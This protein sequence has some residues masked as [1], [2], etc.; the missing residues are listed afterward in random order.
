MVAEH[1]LLGLAS[2]VIL[3]VMGLRILRAASTR[4]AKALAA[5]ML[6]YSVLSLSVDG[7]RLVAP[8]FA[9]GISSAT[10]ASPRRRRASVAQAGAGSR[11]VA[12]T[13]EAG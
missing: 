5:A 8:G 9:F 11:L 6:A 4:M 12:L 1:G 7:M 10:L 13:R 2:L 3:F